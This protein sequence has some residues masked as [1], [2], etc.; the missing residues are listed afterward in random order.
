MENAIGG[1]I[2]KKIEKPH[3]KSF[4]DFHNNNLALYLCSS[5]GK[6]ICYLCQKN[7]TQPYLCP[8]CIHD[9]WVKKCKKGTLRHLQRHYYCRNRN[10]CPV[11]ICFYR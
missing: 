1:E 10:Y 3:M 11:Y 8:D 7:R 5:C 6:S 2:M 9:Y 4:C